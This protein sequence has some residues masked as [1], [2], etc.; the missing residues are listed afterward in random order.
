MIRLTNAN[1]FATILHNTKTGAASGSYFT[2]YFPKFFFTTSGCNYVRDYKNMEQRIF[3]PFAHFQ[4]L[5]LARSN[6]SSFLQRVL[7]EFLCA[8]FDSL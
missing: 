3:S 1:G 2:M 6:I 8:Y 7:L 5:R 4:R